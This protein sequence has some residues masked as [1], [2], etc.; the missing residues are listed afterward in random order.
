M[1]V[2]APTSEILEEVPRSNPSRAGPQKVRKRIRR[3]PRTSHLRDIVLLYGG[4]DQMA[5]ARLWPYAS[6]K[7]YV[8]CISRLL[9]FVAQF[10]HSS[11]SERD[12]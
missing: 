9:R 5:E 2:V 10:S 4:A 3:H 6:P 12:P 11:R 1:A 7:M 8:I